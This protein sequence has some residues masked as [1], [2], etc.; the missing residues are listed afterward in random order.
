MRD[1][2]LRAQQM[3]QNAQQQGSVAQGGIGTGPGAPASPAAPQAQGP[4]M[5]QVVPPQ[6]NFM[7]MS[8]QMGLGQMRLDS[9][10]AK[11]RVQLLQQLHQK[12]G[13]DYMSN[14]KVAS[15]LEAFN[16]HATTDTTT[17][18]EPLAGNLKALL[19]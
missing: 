2:F 10:P 17:V 9:N 3:H 4:T 16:Q 15:L 13:N 19:G 7:A 1:P 6:Q 18:D 11:A 5:Q 12:F 8:K 14:P